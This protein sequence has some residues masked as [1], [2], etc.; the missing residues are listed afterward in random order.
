MFCSRVVSIAC[1]DGAASMRRRCEE[2]VKYEPF[3]KGLAIV[4]RQLPFTMESFLKR[5]TSTILG[6]HRA[7]V[8]LM[9]FLKRSHLRGK[10]SDCI[11]SASS[12]AMR[13][14][15]IKS[16]LRLSRG[17]SPQAGSSYYDLHIPCVRIRSESRKRRRRNVTTTPSICNP[18]ETL[19]R[20][21][22]EALLSSRDTS[23]NNNLNLLYV[24]II[25]LFIHRNRYRRTPMKVHAVF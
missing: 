18:E 5:K 19:R 9:G 24:F 11:V 12:A 8:T 21:E 15:Q 25:Y 1:V 20:I 13:K 4:R 10:L 23:S 16:N 3:L 6:L 14:F 2:M 17:E 7:I 22:K